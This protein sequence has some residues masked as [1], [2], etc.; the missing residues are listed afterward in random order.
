MSLDKTGIE[1]IAH[2]AR[3]TLSDEEAAA[4]VRDLGGILDLVDR[5]KAVDTE[6]IDPL[7][8]A[9]ELPARLR[10]DEV[11]E[12][13]ARE[14]FQAVAPAVADGFYLVPRVIE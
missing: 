11:T 5:I 10:A 6:G 13:D 2:L 12:G 7:F 14:R 8:H 1:R 3:L 9:L 4:L